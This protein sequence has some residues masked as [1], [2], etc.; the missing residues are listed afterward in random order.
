MMAIS[1]RWLIKQSARGLLLAL[2]AI[3]T[4]VVTL[5]SYNFAHRMPYRMLYGMGASYSTV[6]WIEQNAAYLLHFAGGF[7]LTVLLRWSELP[8]TKR[9]LH[10]CVAIVIGLC[11]SAEI[12]QYLIGRGA[13]TSDLLLGI[14]GSFV[15]YLAIFKNQ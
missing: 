1:K 14:S 2:G 9:S 12:F 4:Y 5:P 3:M 11:V 15:A 6:L 10:R 8:L 13:E 7:V